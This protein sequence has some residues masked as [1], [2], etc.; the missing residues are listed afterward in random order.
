M[1]DNKVKADEVV[2]AP[3]E[4]PK[5]IE[6]PG[7]IWDKPGDEPAGE[8]LA[9]DPKELEMGLIVE[10]EHADTIE[11]IK[12]FVTEH[13]GQFPTNEQIY[14][15]IVENHLK[16]DPK[17]Y[18]KLDKHVETK[19]D[20]E[21]QAVDN[22][23]ADNVSQTEMADMEEKA[24]HDPLIQVRSGEET[25]EC[26]HCGGVANFEGHNEGQNCKK[27]GDWVCDKC[28]DWKASGDEDAL[29]KNCSKVKVKACY[30]IKEK[31]DNM[32]NE[33]VE[34]DSDKAKEFDTKEEAEKWA[35]KNLQKPVGSAF[36]GWK[37][38]EASI[39]SATRMLTEEDLMGMAEGLGP[40]GELVVKNLDGT[41]IPL[42]E[43]F[44]N[45]TKNAKEEVVVAKD[46]IEYTINKI[47]G[48]A[49]FLKVN[50]KGKDYF[51]LTDGTSI[52]FNEIDSQ[53]LGIT[54]IPL[55]EI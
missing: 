29:C 28:V 51:G 17:Y 9:F 12:N 31:V 38:V 23:V 10:A 16:E 25:C 15:K 20:I 48:C 7:S 4:S 54:S 19:V 6:V 18:S 42:S 24:K 26:S 14:T 22:M 3:V 44:S 37:V 8:G 34:E 35:K 39:K 49:N 21:E 5:D 55:V 27:C 50:I 47:E 11:W 41:T 32:W 43:V 46:N 53:E 45:L 52:Y 30:I 36:G 40:D 1:A 13:N 33:V 2:E